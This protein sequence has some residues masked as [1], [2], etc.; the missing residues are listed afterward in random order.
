MV[1][2]KRVRDPNEPFDIRLA[3][4]MPRQ[5]VVCAYE[6]E[7]M[8]AQELPD[9]DYKYDS[10]DDELRETWTM[11]ANVESPHKTM[12]TTMAGVIAGGM[13]DPVRVCYDG[14]EA[15]GEEGSGTTVMNDKRKCRLDR[16]G[17]FEVSLPKRAHTKD[18]SPSG[19]NWYP[20]RLRSPL[21]QE[22]EWFEDDDFNLAQLKL[23]ALQVGY[24]LYVNSTCP[25]GTIVAPEDG[26]EPL[27]LEAAKR[28]AT[29]V[30]LVEEKLFRHISPPGGVKRFISRFS[31]I[32]QQPPVGPEAS[33]PSD[34][35]CRA[36]MDAAVPHI[37]DDDMRER[38]NR[39]WG[40]ST[41]SEL[42]TLLECPEGK[43]LG[44]TFYHEPEDQTAQAAFN[45][46]IWH[47]H[48]HTYDVKK[49]WLA[50]SIQFVQWAL[51]EVAD[52][53]RLMN[54]FFEFLYGDR[55]QPTREK[56]FER[57]MENL[58]FD[59]RW[60]LDWLRIVK[61]YGH[62]GKLGPDEI[63]RYGSLPYPGK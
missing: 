36:Y 25:Y 42:I 49:Y 13:G 61:E 48:R 18:W 24:R 52:Y 37:P 53:K 50:L 21:I 32:A 12:L 43:P 45:Y 8:V 4:T 16:Y 44:L 51:T 55:K 47:P 30:W 9:Y 40:A 3:A 20:V 54:K 26:N 35:A 23:I 7:F 63:D 29:M 33:K 38:I 19:Y 10:S 34:L 11:S 56:T 57:L 39:I 14:L 1:R 6:V 31:R 2:K 22:E 59:K 5:E 28:M 60:V 58:V 46:A 41:L 17:F 15:F 27:N 62:G